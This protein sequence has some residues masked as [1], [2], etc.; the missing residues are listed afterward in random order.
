MTAV[1]YFSR[2]TI[3]LH[4]G[5]ESKPNIC[6]SQKP[7]M[8]IQSRDKNSPRNQPQPGQVAQSVEQWTENPR[9][10]SSILSLATIHFL[11]IKVVG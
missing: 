11:Q 8:A 3:L 7:M 6:T 2:S 9:V 1:C 10:G 5:V 4:F